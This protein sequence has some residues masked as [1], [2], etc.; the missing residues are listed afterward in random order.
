[1]NYLIDS[2]IKWQFSLV[3]FEHD[4]VFWRTMIQAVAY[5]KFLSIEKQTLFLVKVACNISYHFGT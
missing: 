3:A 5:D 2:G 4:K 1:M